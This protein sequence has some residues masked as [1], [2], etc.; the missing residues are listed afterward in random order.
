MGTAGIVAA[1]P[2]GYLF[3]VWMEANVMPQT[4]TSRLAI[5]TKVT[6]DQVLGGLLWQAALLSINE[7]YRAAAVG[8]M[9]RSAKHV[10]EVFCKRQRCACT[11]KTVD[12]KLS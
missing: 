7:S 1:G 8:L 5:T 6:L 4:P 9:E 10:N 11:Q 3:I 12:A 2:L